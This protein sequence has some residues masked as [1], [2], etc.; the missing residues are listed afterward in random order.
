M[1]TCNECGWVAQEAN[2][3]M[4]CPACGEG[5]MVYSPY[6]AAIALASKMEQ[7]IEEAEH[8]AELDDFITEL[9]EGEDALPE[10]RDGRWVFSSPGLIREGFNRRLR[11]GDLVRSMG[12]VFE[13]L[14]YSYTGRIYIARVFATTWP[15]KT[16]ELPK[17]FRPR[18]QRKKKEES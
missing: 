14:G 2:T 7:T 6:A 15:D 12:I 17:G 16:G 4:V 3:G 1:Y 9:P 10:Q 8:E 5:R 11:E 18:R 13:I